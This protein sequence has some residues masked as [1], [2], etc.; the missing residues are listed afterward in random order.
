MGSSVS[1]TQYNVP[2]AQRA[3]RIT[4]FKLSKFLKYRN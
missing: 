4:E 1:L 3:G 2:L